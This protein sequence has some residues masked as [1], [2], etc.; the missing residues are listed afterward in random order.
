MNE[1]QTIKKSQNF[2]VFDEWRGKFRI[3][4]KSNEKPA[5]VTNEAKLHT[6]KQA[7]II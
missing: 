3:V 1:T 2:D 5:K 6:N 7:K 4:N